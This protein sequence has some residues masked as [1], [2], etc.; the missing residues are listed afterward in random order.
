MESRTVDMADIAGL[1]SAK[2]AMEVAAAGGHHMLMVGPPSA[3]AVMLAEALVGIVPPLT[4]RQAAEVAKIHARN[5][6]LDRARAVPPL[7]APHHSATMPVMIGGGQGPVVRPGAVS[8]AHH[9][10][11]FLKDAPE[12]RRDVL[13]AVGQPLQ[14]GGVLVS[15]VSSLHRLP[16]QFQLVA[17]AA[18]CPA[19]HEAGACDCGPGARRYLAR[20]EAA[21]MPHIPIR[22]WLPNP[23]PATMLDEAR[24]SESSAEIRQRVVR[25]RRRAARRWRCH[26]AGLTNQTVPLVILRDERFRPSVTAR[27]PLEEYRSRRRLTP[28]LYDDILRLAW[29]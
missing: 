18:L 4:A 26:A 27:E 19:G 25:A 13:H 17:S 9:G 2:K 16:A 14:H 29:T 15:R 1:D 24:T 6:C 3:G 12:F 8:L 28:R 11:L 5:P 10:V 20:L 22:I 23:T 7:S 21:L